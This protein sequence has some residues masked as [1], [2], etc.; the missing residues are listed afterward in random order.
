M[1]SRFSLVWLT[2]MALFPFSVCLLKF[3]RGRL[4][5]ESRAS[6]A[7]VFA[8]LAIVV[9]IIGGNIAIDPSIAGCI[10]FTVVMDST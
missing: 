6:L 5:R 9:T 4:P 2:V 3:N 7:L 8:A 10:W 1:Y